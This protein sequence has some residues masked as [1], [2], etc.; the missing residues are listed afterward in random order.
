M[1]GQ[2][3]S[4]WSAFGVRF[5]GSTS[6]IDEILEKE[7]HTLEELL[8]HDDIIQECKY[9]TSALVEYLSQRDVVE[10]L[11]RYVIAKPP[12]AKGDEKVPEPK[13]DSCGTQSAFCFYF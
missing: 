1:N 4:F 11:I 13:Y 6:A 8:D 9:M 7:G 2:G 3:G 10:K 5:G 12:E